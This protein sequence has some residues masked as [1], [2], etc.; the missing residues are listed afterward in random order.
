M[1]PAIF[2]AANSMNDLFNGSTNLAASGVIG[3]GFDYAINNNTT[4]GMAA[5]FGGGRGP[6]VAPP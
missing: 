4:F 2:S 1:R 6:F 3:A 5:V